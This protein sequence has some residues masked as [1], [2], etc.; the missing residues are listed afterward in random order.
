MIQMR[1]ISRAAKT[2]PSF[3]MHFIHFH[4]S[5]QSREQEDFQT[6]P[7][8]DE[9]DYLQ[10]IWNMLTANKKR[11]FEIPIHNATG[12]LILSRRTC[13]RVS[14]PPWRGLHA[15]N[16]R[17]RRNYFDTFQFYFSSS[18]RTVGMWY[19]V[20]LEIATPEQIKQSGFDAITQTIGNHTNMANSP[21]R[22]PTNTTVS[23]SLS[24]SSPSPVLSVSP[25][26]LWVNNSR[27]SCTF[28]TA[29]T[30]LSDTLAVLQE[31]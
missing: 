5:L 1:R 31:I 24:Y 14:F 11:D 12:R 27:S 6:L 2:S 18:W 8:G 22:A 3:R 30:R 23:D 20:S 10:E 9:L 21:R 26:L 29:L 15:A 13:C 16:N 7:N 19:L 28:L 25:N 17:C 4:S